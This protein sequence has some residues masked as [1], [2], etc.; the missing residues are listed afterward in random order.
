[1]A[2]FEGAKLN[3][4]AGKTFSRLVVSDGFAPADK[5][6]VDDSLPTVLPD[7]DWGGV[8]EIVIPKGLAV[9]VKAA[10]KDPESGK[11]V[12]VLTIADGTVKATGIAPYNIMRKVND[13]LY[14]NLPSMITRDYIE[15]P[16]FTAAT[17]VYANGV[18]SKVATNIKFPWGCAYGTLAVGDYVTVDAGGRL[19][20]L[21]DPDA[22]YTS[23]VGQ[24]LAMDTDIPPAGWLQWLY[25]EPEMNAERRDD[26]NFT[27]APGVE[28]YG[29]DPAYKEVTD[30]I[31]G[32]GIK[33]LTDGGGI[34]RTTVT[35]EVLATPVTADAGATM[36]LRLDHPTPY[37]GS[38]K[39]YSTDTA[40]TPVTTELTDFTVNLENGWVT[41]TFADAQDGC[42]ITADY[43]YQDFSKA[44]TPTA[45][46][47]QGA[48]G[49]VRILLKF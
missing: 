2:L 30:K 39:I 8:G 1:M 38:V 11:Y 35:G 27:P 31:S 18:A 10:V 9:G 15:L 7:Y 32:R 6:L 17:S 40:T 41:L 23:I 28:G 37:E 36:I 25:Q 12:T 13:R 19:V 4:T 24:V 48:A 47:F 43:D 42:T 26:A 49:A 34:G 22:K 45:W 33:G 29:Y 20:K 46:D 14:H 3:T 44:G 16:Y 21:A 5:W